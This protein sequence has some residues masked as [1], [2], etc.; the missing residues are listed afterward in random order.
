LVAVSVTHACPQKTAGVVHRVVQAKAPASLAAQA[1]TPP[2][3]E[4]VHTLPHRPHDFVELDETH[5]P[6][7]SISP[8]PQ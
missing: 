6:L 2:S 7:H 4:S 8:E 5:V 1:G 3:A